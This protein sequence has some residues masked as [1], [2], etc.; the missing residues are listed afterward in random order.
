M[1]ISIIESS[2]ILD[3]IIRMYG[4]IEA[5]GRL[6]EDSYEWYLPK[7]LPMGEVYT[8]TNMAMAL[9]HK[10]LTALEV[11]PDDTEYDVN[12]H[13]KD[14][15]LLSRVRFKYERDLLSLTQE[16]SLAKVEI[17]RLTSIIDDSCG[18]C[19]V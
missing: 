15:Y 8:I 16:L 7:S 12:I 2:I 10:A 5:K 4:T 14:M 6:P 1:L 17:I 3:E 18:C 11:A 19:S 9:T 13:A